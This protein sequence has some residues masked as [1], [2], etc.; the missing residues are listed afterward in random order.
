M[1][2]TIFGNRAESLIEF[3]G[4][5][6]LD[7]IK[8][9]LLKEFEKMG[10]ADIA[11]W[12]LKYPSYREELLEFWLWAKDLGTDLTDTDEA[13]AVI[14]PD[15]L[16]QSIQNACLAV[17][18]GAQWLE[19]PVE[20]KTGELEGIGSQLASVRRRSALKTRAPI[21]FQKA[22]VCTWVVSVLQEKRVRVSRLA[23]QKTTYL[24]ESAMALG[25]FAEHDRKPLGPY[26]YKAR[27]KDAE[28]IASK[29]GWLL[30]SG[31]TFRASDDLREVNRFVGRYLKSEKLARRLVEQLAELTDQQLETLTTV[32]WVVRE[33]AASRKEPTVAAVE[34]R[35]AST[36]EWSSKLTRAN[37]SADCVHEAITFLQHL[38]LVPA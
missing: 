35:L 13:P 29:K 25:I 15:V 26:D 34:A 21:A 27:Y 17:N 22:V 33:L 32:H 20:P 12:V 23:M 9:E 1:L 11:E 28:P 37:F 10:N 19:Q 24:L 14:R 18:L 36:A 7:Q 2:S 16:E 5:D 8:F 3:S 6:P 38:H 31:N 30:E 4:M